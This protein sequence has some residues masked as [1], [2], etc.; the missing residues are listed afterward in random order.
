MPMFFSHS[1]LIFRDDV[2]FVVVCCAI[3]GVSGA[4]GAERRASAPTT[5]AAAPSADK[6]SVICNSCSYYSHVNNNCDSIIE[7]FLLAFRLSDYSYISQRLQQEVSPD[8]RISNL[9]AIPSKGDGF[10]WQVKL[11]CNISMNAL[12]IDLTKCSSTFSQY[13]TAPSSFR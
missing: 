11:L 7:D 3:A 4:I 5:K 8:K 2:A 12:I 10:Y 6:R 1:G 13:L 9:I